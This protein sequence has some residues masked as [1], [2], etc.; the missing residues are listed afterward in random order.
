MGRRGFSWRAHWKAYVIGTKFD[1]AHRLTMSVRRGQQSL[2]QIVTTAA[3]KCF[4]CM[5]CRRHCQYFRT[6]PAGMGFA[7]GDP[8][9]GF[10]LSISCDSWFLFGRA[11]DEEEPGI[12]PLGA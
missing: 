4:Q 2:N 5:K 11:V 1:A 9:A 6:F 7:R 8:L 3:R 12:K 10:K